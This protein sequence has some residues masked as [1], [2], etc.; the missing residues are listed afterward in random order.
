MSDAKLKR[1]E[2]LDHRQ[3]DLLKDIIKRIDIGAFDLSSN[4]IFK[5]GQNFISKMMNPKSS[6]Y[7]KF[8]SPFRRQYAEQIVPKIA[9][10]YSMYDAQDSSAFRQSMSQS[11]ADLE[12]NIAGM[13]QS[14]MEGAAQQALG[15]SQAPGYMQ[16]SLVNTALGNSS[17]GYQ[18]IPGTE[19]WGQGLFGGLASAAG[20]MAG[21]YAMN[22]F[23]EWNSSAPASTGNILNNYDFGEY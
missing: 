5:S 12:Q 6:I 23:N 9:E 17:F 13:R 4:S 21:S 2:T 10:Q 1:F 14:A 19:G 20:S 18:A 16:Q 3:R 7:Q 15:Y 8:E 22:R 11:A